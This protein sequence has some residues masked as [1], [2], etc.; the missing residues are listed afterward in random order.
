MEKMDFE[1]KEIVEKS[2][3]WRK[4]VSWWI[5]G[6]EGLALVVIGIYTFFQTAQSRQLIAF[7]VGGFLLISS[8][9][10]AYSGLRTTEASLAVKSSMLRSGVGL[11]VGILA[12]LQPFTNVF[13]VSVSFYFIGVGLLIYGVTGIA[14]TFAKRPVQVQDEEEAKTLVKT[15]SFFSSLLNIAFGIL[16]ML[17]IGGELLPWFAGLAIAAGLGFLGYAFILYNAQTRPKATAAMQLE[18][19]PKK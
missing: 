9:L 14:E 11:T 5:L 6:I 8:F 3:P 18:K 15:G 16:I 4:G 13:D 7:G 12:I 19:A 1:V 2:I 10:N 17:A